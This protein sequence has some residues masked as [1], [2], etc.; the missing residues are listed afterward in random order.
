MSKKSKISKWI[1]ITTTHEIYNS[2]LIKIQW[3]LL[4]FLLVWE[5]LRKKFCFLDFLWFNKHR[6]TCLYD[7]VAYFSK[8]YAWWS[9]SINKFALLLVGR[10]CCMTCMKQSELCKSE[11]SQQALV[12]TIQ[13]R[14]EKK[15]LEKNRESAHSSSYVQG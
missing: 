2:S 12:K 6:E 11:R 10:T 1:I 15:K 9:S 14:E 8:Y 4:S 13:Q 7:D 5:L 3:S